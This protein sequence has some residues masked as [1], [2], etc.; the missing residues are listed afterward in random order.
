MKIDLEDIQ[1]LVIQKK[2]VRINSDKYT[3][4]AFSYVKYLIDQ[5]RAI[6]FDADTHRIYTLGE[7]YGGDELKENLLYF[8]HLLSID[9]DDNVLGEID[10]IQNSDTLAIKGKGALNVNFTNNDKYNIIELEYS[11][12][13]AINNAAHKFNP[14]NEYNLYIDENG[15]IAL[16]EYIYPVLEII[17]Q[18]LLLSDDVQ[19]ILHLNISTSV[20]VNDW[21]EFEIETDNCTINHYDLEEK[22]INVTLNKGVDNV[23]TIHYSDGKNS[24]T[25]TYIQKWYNVCTYGLFDGNNYIES[26][27]ILFIDDNIEPFVIDQ[28]NK[29]VGYVILP[30]YIKPIFKDNHR[31]MQGAWHKTHA[32]FYDDTNYE[33]YV[34]DNSGLGKIEWKIINKNI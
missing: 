27:Q 1:D 21:P 13:N 26:D 25:Y 12:Q 10:A 14:N 7:Y 30:K 16:N 34:T 3:D 23:I 19:Q 8:S 15:K 33:L 24:N 18:P 4:N 17:G 5:E 2:F 32:Y 28:K 29:F 31:G 9:I 11:L 20:N 6:L 22:T